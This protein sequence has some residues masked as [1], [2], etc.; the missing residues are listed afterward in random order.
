MAAVNTISD[1]TKPKLETRNQVETRLQRG[2]DRYGW[3][4]SFSMAL[5]MSYTGDGGKHTMMLLTPVFL[6]LT[7]PHTQLLTLGAQGFNEPQN[8][9]K[10]GRR[11]LL[12]R[13]V[14]H[15]IFLLYISEYVSWNL[16]SS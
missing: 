11:S 13:I 4:P 5:Q 12:Q 1:F 14:L 6:L 3:N 16:L 2:E 7:A 8:L 10:L 15:G 9:G